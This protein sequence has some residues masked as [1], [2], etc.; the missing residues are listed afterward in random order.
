MDGNLR[1]ASR[2]DLLALITT[3]RATV[4]EQQ[5]VIATVQQRVH[6]LERKLGSGGGKGMPGTKPATDSRSTVTGRPRRPRLHGFARQRSSTPTRTVRHAA[7]H[8][9]HCA[10]RLVGGWEQRRREVI[11][12]PVAPAEVVAHVVIARTCPVCNR[13]IV[14]PLALDDVVVG[15]QRLS[16]RLISL[17]ATL[18]EEGRLPVQT[19]QWLLGQLY[20]LPLSVGAIVAAS[21]QV[22]HASVALAS[23]IRDQIRASPVVHADETGWRENGVNGYVWTFSTP[24]ARYFVRRNRGKAVVDEVLGDRFAGVLSSDFY[25]AYHHYPGLKQRCWAHLLREIHDLRRTYPADAGLTAWATAV[26]ALFQHA[27]QYASGAAHERVQAQQQYEHRLLRLCQ[28]YLHD[29]VAVQGKLCRRIQR[30]LCELFVFVAHPDVPADNNAAERSLRHLVTARKISG[31]TRA[32]AGTT[33]KMTT[34]TVFG[35]WRL[36]G[37]NPFTAAL[38]LLLSPQV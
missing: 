3:L 20:A 17:I 38:Q 6:D 35:T 28:P 16:A 21:A 11:D 37:L 26:H 25:A 32:P 36:Q 33:T 34:A 30:H 23:A 24:S 14:P 15:R 31:G 18:R 13:R 22:A 27:V 10:T 12:L 2:E 1:T 4:A 29:P 19:I 9:P 8:C 7:D 5:A